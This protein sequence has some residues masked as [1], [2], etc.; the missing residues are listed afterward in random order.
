MSHRLR[1]GTIRGK[2]H[3]SRNHILPY[4]GDRPINP[5]TPAD[6]RAWQNQIMAKGL[7]EGYLYRIQGVY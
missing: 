6:I 5:I 1:E 4:L 2:E 3:V 7:S